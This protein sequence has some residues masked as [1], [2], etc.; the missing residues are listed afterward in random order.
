MDKVKPQRADIVSKMQSCLDRLGVSLKVVW[1]PKADSS[2]H[3]EI[4]S[5]CLLIYDQDQEEAWLTFQHEVYE[6]KL[7]EVTGV[8]RTLINSLIEGYEKLAYDRKEQMLEFL[9][10]V[11]RIVSEEKAQVA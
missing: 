3:G 8:Y 9:P 5:N 2:K 6:Y 11:A 10:T 4:S 1:T 7:K